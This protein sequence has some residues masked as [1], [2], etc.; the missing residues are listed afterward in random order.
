MEN[1]L[2]RPLTD[3]EFLKMPG[4][5]ATIKDKKNTSN[6]APA[7]KNQT[8]ANNNTTNTEN[9]AP[10]FNDKQVDASFELELLSMMLLKNGACIPTVSAI[11]E[12]DDF[13]NYG[14]EL[15]YST[16]CKQYN[17]KIIPTVL[18]LLDELRDKVDLKTLLDLG[19]YAFTTAYAEQYAYTIKEKSKRAKIIKDAQRLIAESEKGAT[20]DELF[21]RLH[22]NLHSL[23]GGVS[24]IKLY[25]EEDYIDDIFPADV[26]EEKKYLERMTGFANIDDKQNFSPGLYVIG[27]T[28]AC[29]KTTFCWQMLEQLADLGNENNW[30]NECIFCSYEMS[31][32]EMYSKT[33][34]RELFKRDPATTL[35]AADIRRGA[36]SNA[37]QEIL[38][39]VSK[40]RGVKLIELQDENIDDLLRF[41]KPLCINRD[42]APVVCV[43]Y[44]QIIP[45]SN[46]RRLITDKMKIDDIV[47]KLKTFQRETNTTFIVISSFN[48]LNYYQQV[49]FESF[50]DSGNI[51]YSADVVWGLQ[52]DVV[53]FIKNIKN[54]ENI[55]NI[56]KKF[57]DAKKQQPRLIQLKCLKNRQGNNYDCYFHYYSAHDHFQFLDDIP[58][59][60]ETNSTPPTDECGMN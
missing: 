35:T 34:S 24:R 48:R 40:R 58:E 1:W 13:Q 31:R 12:P 44:L 17:N 41:L 29:G 9:Q 57:E 7:T 53:N 14:F 33:L 3:E 11:L 55:S 26:E 10:K 15:I 20:Y 43:D 51:E 4:T 28:P 50:K 46:D 21:Q 45:P 6:D 30:G 42:R 38:K 56:R 60:K 59:E 16:I 39:K 27:A 23:N 52:L 54:G 18:T 49:S 8:V 5:K 47:R 25:S 36:T 22:S 37:L 2:G 19:D 32:K